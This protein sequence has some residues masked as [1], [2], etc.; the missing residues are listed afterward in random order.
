MNYGIK[1]LIVENEFAVALDI[2]SR[3]G[4]MGFI[5]AGIAAT[6]EEAISHT[7]SENPDVVLMDIQIDGNKSGIDAAQIIWSKFEVPV[8]YLTGISETEVMEEAMLTSPMGYILKP[9]KDTDIYNQLL[10]ATQQKK[11]LKLLEEKIRQYENIISS[12]QQG[13]TQPEIVFLKDGRQIYKL[14]ADEIIYLEAM[15][16]YTLLYSVNNEKYMM[17]GVL[18]EIIDKIGHPHIIRIHRSYAI[19]KQHIKKIEENTVTIGDRVLP[20]SKSYR[21]SFYAAINPI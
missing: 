17:N 6:F 1:V 8:V 15:D 3:L 10:I 20:V 9:F 19:A 13:T 12:V 5:S 4:K 11:A 14:V 18:K 2:Q 7:A 21:D 16:N